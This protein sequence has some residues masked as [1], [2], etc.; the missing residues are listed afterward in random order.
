MSK[1]I[2]W[3]PEESAKL[4]ELLEA[5][6]PY[7]EIAR[8]IGRSRTSC[9]SHAFRAGMAHPHKA[10]DE[11]PLD[12]PVYTTRKCLSCL[13]PFPSLSSANRICNPCRRV[14]ERRL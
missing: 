9:E 13:L 8:I 11:E 3:T 6:T 2:A 7:R 5:K 10:I 14:I 4:K 12:V 1:K